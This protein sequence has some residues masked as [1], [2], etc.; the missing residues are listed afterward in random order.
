MAKVKF[1]VICILLLMGETLMAQTLGIINGHEYVDLGLSVM[2]ATC[3]VGANSPS[4][5]GDYF[6]RGE[7]EPKSEYTEENSV[8]YKKKRMGSIADDPQYDAART[9]WGGIWRLPTTEEIDELIDKCECERTTYGGTKGYKVTGPNGNS[10]FLPATG[11][12]SESSLYD[13]GEEGIYWS[14]TPCEDI[15]YG[16]YGLGFLS[17]NFFGFWDYRYYGQTMRPVS[18]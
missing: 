4:E 13:A 7:T 1:L 10:I 16:T 9:N 2:W 18:E 6:A 14:A 11:W 12:R 15:A 3:N 8:T 5:Y 17:Y